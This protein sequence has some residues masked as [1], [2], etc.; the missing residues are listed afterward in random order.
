L[1]QIVNGCYAHSDIPALALCLATV[2]TKICGMMHFYHS[3]M[4]HQ[5][6]GSCLPLNIWQHVIKKNTKKASSTQLLRRCPDSGNTQQN[7]LWKALSDLILIKEVVIC[8]IDS[9]IFLIISIL[10]GILWEGVSV[11]G[12]GT[13]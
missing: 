4:T 2:V 5:S 10:P 13:G 7:V 1:H 6:G 12:S 11:R 8:N 3:E 9:H